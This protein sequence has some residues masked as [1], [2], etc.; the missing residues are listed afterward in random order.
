MR[1]RGQTRG[2]VRAKAVEQPGW[3]WAQVRGRAK[4]QV[5][6]GVGHT[7]ALLAQGLL[8]SRRLSFPPLTFQSTV[9][10]ASANVFH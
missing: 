7:Q 6:E 1:R 9:P 8:F 2:G 5:G 10:T 4:L 3:E